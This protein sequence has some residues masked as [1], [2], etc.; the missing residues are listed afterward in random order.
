LCFKGHIST[1]IQREN[2]TNFSVTPKPEKHSG[3]IYCTLASPQTPYTVSHTLASR[4]SDRELFDK[5]VGGGG[6][7]HVHNTYLEVITLKNKITPF[8]LT[9]LFL[10]CSAEI[11][12]F[13]LFSF[14]RSASF[15]LSFLW[16]T[17]ILH[18][19]YSI[20]VFP[21][22]ELSYNWFLLFFFSFISLIKFLSLYTRSFSN[23][24]L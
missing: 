19:F 16:G 24:A 8:S 23:F 21:L 11:I 17:F 15:S 14:V 3:V 6:S 7:G 4:T 2:L 5:R 22:T 1:E 20:V 13:S 10:H 9:S 12:L 18:V